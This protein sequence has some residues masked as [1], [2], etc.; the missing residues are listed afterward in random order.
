MVCQTFILD[1]L[2]WEKKLEAGAQDG[3]G[4]MRVVPVTVCEH[5]CG[6]CHSMGR[7][8]FDSVLEEE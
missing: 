6:F 8:E 7:K 1:S 4:D 5:V 3:D 2:A